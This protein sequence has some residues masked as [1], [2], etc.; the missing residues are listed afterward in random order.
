[1]NERDSNMQRAVRPKPI[2]GMRP[3]LINEKS[4]SI[5]GYSMSDKKSLVL[6][7]KTTSRRGKLVLNCFTEVLRASIF[8]SDMVVELK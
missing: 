8:A 2:C 7:K 5:D 6:H 1:M 3:D 4:V